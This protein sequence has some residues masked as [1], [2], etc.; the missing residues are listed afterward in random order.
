MSEWKKAR[1]WAT[2]YESKDDKAYFMIYE[3]IEKYIDEDGETVEYTLDELTFVYDKT[4]TEELHYIWI[5]GQPSV[6]SHYGEDT[7]NAL[8]DRVY[9]ENRLKIELAL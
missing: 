9:N 4:N 6:Y 2:Q 1:Q 8:K 5:M 3:L 7:M